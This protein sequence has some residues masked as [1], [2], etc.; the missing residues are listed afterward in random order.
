MQ[1]ITSASKQKE[2]RLSSSLSSL[3]LSFAALAPVE[4]LS[5]AL[6]DSVGCCFSAS[7][8]QQ[9]KK[10]LKNKSI[11]YMQRLD[12]GCLMDAIHDPFRLFYC[13]TGNMM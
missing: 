5:V 10:Y 9:N 3:S 6:G 12:V 11:P 2:R 13:I 7:L 4:L 8:V 1:T